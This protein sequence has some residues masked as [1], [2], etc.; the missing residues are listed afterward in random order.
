MMFLVSLRPIVMNGPLKNV[1]SLVVAVLQV[2]V[3]VE[4]G[5]LDQV[6][7]GWNLA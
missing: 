6:L 2:G 3:C 4:A 1:D 7:Q 5:L